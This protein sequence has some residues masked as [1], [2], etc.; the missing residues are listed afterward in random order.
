MLL[1]KN[2]ILP[3]ILLR[4]TKVQCADSLALPPR[5]L[6]LR[7]D[8]FDKNEADFYEALYTQSQASFGSY[9]ESGTLLNNYAHIFDLLI[10]LRQ[11]VC[12]PYL[13][14]YSATAAAGGRPALVDARPASAANREAEEAG[15]LAGSATKSDASGSESACQLCHDELEDEIK[16]SCGHSF[17]RLCLMEYVESA[18]SDAQAR[19]PIVSCKQLLTFDLSRADD[20]ATPVK[21]AKKKAQSHKK[22][23]IINRIKVDS[24]TSSTKIEALREEIS[25]MIERDPGAKCLVFSQFTSMLQLIA[26]RLESVGIKLVKLEGSMTLAQRDAAINTFTNDAD[27]RVFLMSLKAGGVALN[28]TVASHVFLIDPWWNPAVESQAMDR[29]HRLGQYKPI[30]VVRFIIAG[31]IEERILKLQEKK[32][33]VFEGTVGRDLAALARLTEDDLKFLFH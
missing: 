15:A 19:C 17:C 29:I 20:D 7:K 23:S 26:F 10:R 32:A 2:Q 3:K 28:L 4:R 16:S 8:Q 12:H 24:F 18:A 31:T 1:L 25:R 6:I 11:A 5:T 9:V 30:T 14:V 21:P 13:V 27:T 22:S 33:L